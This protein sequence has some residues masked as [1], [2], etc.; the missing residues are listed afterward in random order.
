MYTARNA[1]FI[2]TLAMSACERL[3]L[4]TIER[5]ISP[6]QFQIICDYTPLAVPRLVIS[7]VTTTIEHFYST[8]PDP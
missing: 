5:E 3:T 4:I 6:S 7:Q 2:Y 1:I 8:A